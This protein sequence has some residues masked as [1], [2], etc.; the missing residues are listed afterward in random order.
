MRLPLVGQAAAVVVGL[1]VF[2]PSGGYAQVGQTVRSGSSLSAQGPLPVERGWIGVGVDLNVVGPFSGPTDLVVRIV[3]TV[4]GGPAAA[5][6]IVPGDII[7]AIDGELL[8]IEGW[9][10]FAQSLRPGVELRLVVDREGGS[11]DLRLTTA[12][13][14]NLPPAPTGLTTHLDSVRTSFR[15]QLEFGKGVWASRDYVT[16]LMTGD[17]GRDASARILDRVRQNAV[18]YRSRPEPMVD[19]V[20]PSGQGANRYSVVWNTDGA[21]PFEYLMLQSPEA[22]SVKS[23]MVHLRGELNT[24]VEATRFREQEIREIVELSTRRMGDGD[25]QLLR[26]RSD[27]ER[28][29]EDLERLAVRLAEIGTLERDSRM[30]SGRNTPDLTVSPRPVT[31]SVAGRS[32]V[33]GAQFNDLNPQLGTYFGTDR[34]VLVIQVLSGTPCDEAGLVPGDVVTHVGDTEIESVEGFRAELNRVFAG[35]RRA[36]LSLLRKGERIAA[37]LSR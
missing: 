24:V 7:R 5:V 20:A 26:L 33:G 25:A 19:V 4:D 29:Q 17:T 3:R 8:T 23:A 13:R 31:A 16:L 15:T 27:N 10:R 6:G 11:R 35:G 34:G 28:V 21:L 37:T 36:E 14:P 1:T 32:F 22:D 9:Q 12:P 2:N 30:G 18:G